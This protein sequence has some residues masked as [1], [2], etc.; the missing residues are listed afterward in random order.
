VAKK[1]LSK[2]IDMAS[3]AKTDMRYWQERVFFPAYTRNGKKF[4]SPQYAARIQHQNRRE[5]FALHTA[6]KTAAAARAKEICSFLTAH[7]WDE[8]LA[9]Y[10]PEPTNGAVQLVTL[11]DLIREVKAAAAG[12]G[13][14]L[15]DY[16]RNFRKLVAGIFGIDGGTEKY[17]YQKGGAN[18]GF[19]RSM[20]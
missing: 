12:R 15:D 4:F 8:T 7:G 18:L 2:T 9:K 5:T 14:T 16:C 6:N 17:D 10:K 13:R 1:W 3:F 20:R 11:G 19:K